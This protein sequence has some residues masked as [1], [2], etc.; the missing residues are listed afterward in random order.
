MGG[1]AGGA[2]DWEWHQAKVG[3]ALGEGGCGSR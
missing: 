3:G 1:A 2:L